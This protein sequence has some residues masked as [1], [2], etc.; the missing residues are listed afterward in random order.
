[1]FKF[2][3]HT[4]IVFFLST[5]LH[6]SEQKLEENTHHNQPTTLINLDQTPLVNPSSIEKKHKNT[7][8]YVSQQIEK[9]IENREAFESIEDTETLKILQKHLGNEWILFLL[10][11][12][13]TQKKG[14]KILLQKSPLLLHISA[15]IQ[16]QNF[17]LKL[18]SYEDNLTELYIRYHE[19]AFQSNTT[20]PIHE[21]IIA[22][23]KKY[24]LT[25][26]GSEQDTIHQYGK[27]TVKSFAEVTSKEW[28]ADYRNKHNFFPE[29]SYNFK[30]CAIRMEIDYPNETATKTSPQWFIGVE[31]LPF[32]ILWRD[33][34][35]GA[36]SNYNTRYERVIREIIAGSIHNILMQ[37][38]ELVDVDV[39]YGIIFNS[40]MIDD[41][42]QALIPSS[43]VAIEKDA[44][45]SENLTKKI[46]IH[47]F[48]LRLKEDNASTPLE[49]T[50]LDP[51]DPDQF[52]SDIHTSYQGV[53][54]Q[55]ALMRQGHENGFPGVLVVPT[56]AIPTSIS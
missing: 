5:S 43:E 48:N 28:K 10:K 11:K 50:F 16:P 18:P 33:Q 4:C 15:F 14:T 42:N 22:I 53:S 25:L 55:Q 9:R 20:T 27:R 54:I 8:F 34:N 47:A 2:I 3:T 29:V 45:E 6:A 35:E 40:T 12:L 1:M 46:L 23:I 32:Q 7:F 39:F 37:S 56:S 36:L 21:C 26:D 52:S 17:T 44:D 38:I 30:V 13:D 41:E 49:V 31:K 24:G 51:H 19:R